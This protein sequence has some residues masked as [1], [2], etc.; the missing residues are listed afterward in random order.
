MTQPSPAATALHAA[1]AEDTL[2]PLRLALSGGLDS[3]LLLHLLAA[4]PDWRRRL[5]AVH[6]HHGLSPH[7]DEWAAF[8]VAQGAALG[9]PVR[10]ERVQLCPGNGESLEAQARRARYGM[11]ARHLPPGG[12][13][14]TAH[15]GDDQ[16]ETLLLAIKRGSG[17]RGLAGMGARQPFAGGVL[18]RPLLGFARAE[19]AAQAGVLGLTWVEDES[20]GDERFDRNFVRQQLA[21]PLRARWPAILQTAARSMSLCAEAAELLDELAQSDLAAIGE[22]ERLPVAPLNALSPARRANVLRHW[23]RERGATPPSREQLTLLWQEVAQARADANPS[24][25]WDLWRCRRHQGALVVL[26]RDEPA[27]PLSWEAELEVGQWLT[28]PA[29]L[30]RLRLVPSPA[31]PLRAPQGGE[32]LLLR[33]TVAPGCRL[34]PIGRAGS[35]RL[36]KLW[37]EYGVP[38]W[39]R[40]RVPLLHYDETPAAALGVFVCEGFAGTALGWEWQR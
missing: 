11:L 14:L 39:Q 19:L 10:V 25:C 4:E 12:V 18:V 28:L 30:G 33:F 21:P 16:L 29:G 2:A 37:Q 31:G 35:R 7:A 20:N 17:V 1:L 5:E 26:P 6:V 24:L 3:C 9:V 27:A 13:L 22:G 8:C 34:H 23:L 38:S 32:R 36:K 15:H 40:G